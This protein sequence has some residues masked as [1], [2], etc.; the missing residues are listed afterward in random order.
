M[1][2]CVACGRLRPPSDRA[3]VSVHGPGGRSHT[4]S[5]CLSCRRVL[6]QVSFGFVVD[7]GEPIPFVTEGVFVE[8]QSRSR[9]KEVRETCQL[10][11]V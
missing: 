11:Q 1:Y 2:G 4:V 6:R 9:Q 8:W 3:R 7:D 5:V 10:K